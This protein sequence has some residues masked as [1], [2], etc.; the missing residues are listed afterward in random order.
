MNYEKM[1]NELE[2]EIGRSVDLLVIKDPYK[3]LGARDMAVINTLRRVGRL[4]QW[5][6]E[7]YSKEEER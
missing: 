5:I 6:E 4:M 7:K 1:W 2:Y 3:G